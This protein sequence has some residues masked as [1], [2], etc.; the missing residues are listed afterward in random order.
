VQCSDPAA[1][2][3]RFIGVNDD[4]PVSMFG[5]AKTIKKNRPEKAHKV[6]TKQLPN[7]LVRTIGFFEPSVRQLVPQLG[8]VKHCSNEKAK[9][10]LGWTP[11]PSAETIL[12]TFDSL[13]EHN[14]I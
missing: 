13:V 14:I 1:K 6:P 8:G 12:D 4:G 2:G 7:W 9:A 10:V 11:R 5:I 3:E